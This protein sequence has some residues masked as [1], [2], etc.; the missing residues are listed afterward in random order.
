ANGM[1]LFNRFYQP[2]IDPDLM[3]V[4]PHLVWSTSHELRLRIW[5]VGMLYG[6]IPADFAVTG[7]VHTHMDVLKSLMAGAKVAMM[8]S[9]LLK[10][11]IGRMTKILHD[12]T[13]WMEEHEYDSVSRMIGS[14]SQQHV[15]HPD[16]YER[17]Q[18][19]RELHTRR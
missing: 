6:R 7:G 12:L 13:V 19:M 9:E 5:W 11:G 2:D 1:V 4:R 8:A 18:Y 3:Q 17:I 16:V 10:N 14:M 15:E